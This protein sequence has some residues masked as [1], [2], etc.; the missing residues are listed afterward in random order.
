MHEPTAERTTEV[1]RLLAR[2]AAWVAQ[3]ATVRAVAL[4]GSWARGAATMDS[5]VDLVFVCQEPAALLL[6]DGWWSFLD[7]GDLVRRQQWGILAERRVR[8]ASGLEVELGVAPLEWARVP[9]D[10]GTQRVLGDG[11]R[12]LHD[13]AR[14]LQGAIAALGPC[15]RPGAATLPFPRRG[16][17][18]RMSS[19]SRPGARMSEE[20]F[21]RRAIELARQGM[22]QGKGGPFG[23][24]VVLEGRIVGE[25]CNCVTSSADPTAHAE[26]VA[27]RAACAT[28]GR[29]DLH[30]GT[31]YTSCE[32]CPMCLS[33]IYWARLDRIV[34]ANDRADAARIGFDDASIYR[35]VALPPAER[36]VPMVRLL[37][38]EA[39][40]TF[41]AWLRKTDRIPY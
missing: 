37:A 1:E 41:D 34:F 3:E 40:E 28:L 30:G 23:A 6:R 18:T 16:G 32:P 20:L 39:R 12:V 36:S 22:E 15:A 5:D 24:V 27:I 4:V 11:A 14:L 7:G 2:V 38:A 29:F 26:V 19:G 31:V 21:M 9:L 10:A 17:R 13:P 33:A 8:L 35:E 25:G